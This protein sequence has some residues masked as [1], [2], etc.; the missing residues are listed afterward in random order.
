MQQRFPIFS[1]KSGG[2]WFHVERLAFAG[3]INILFSLSV[4]SIAERA[5]DWAVFSSHCP[6]PSD[7]HGG[8]LQREAEH[9]R[10][11]QCQ[12]QGPNQL[13]QCQSSN[14]AWCSPGNLWCLRPWL[15]SD[16]LYP[17]YW[18]TLVLSSIRVYQVIIIATEQKLYIQ[19]ENRSHRKIYFKRP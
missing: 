8:G 9:Q 12:C 19:G 16:K 6:R 2:H 18:H 1:C 17:L 14:S 5:A 15:S 10:C 13:L 3:I 7:Q 4:T 11:A